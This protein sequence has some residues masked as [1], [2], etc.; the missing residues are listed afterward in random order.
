MSMDLRINDMEITQQTG[1]KKRKRRQVAFKT[2]W[3]KLPWRWANALRESNSVSTYRLAH[4]ILFEAFKRKQIGGEI[5]LSTVVTGMSR[6]TRRRAAKELAKLKLIEI[7]QYGKA[8]V[9]VTNL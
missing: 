6:S 9:R 2:R 7:Q 8:T 5:I 3:V 1:K 4:I